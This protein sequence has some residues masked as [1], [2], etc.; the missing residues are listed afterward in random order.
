MGEGIICNQT[1]VCIPWLHVVNF[2]EMIVIGSLN[3]IMIET[4]I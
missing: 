1:E 3:I 2:W 4:K